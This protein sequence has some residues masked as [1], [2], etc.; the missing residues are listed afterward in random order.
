MFALLKAVVNGG[1][2]FFL[3]A[4][5]WLHHSL[6]LLLR[7]S[8]FSPYPWPGQRRGAQHMLNSYLYSSQRGDLCVLLVIVSTGEC[9]RDR[10]SLGVCH[11]YLQEDFTFICKLG[12]LR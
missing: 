6:L 10:G 7:V 2:V 12:G 3:S 9:Q 5:M 8:D 11:L 1:T 4:E